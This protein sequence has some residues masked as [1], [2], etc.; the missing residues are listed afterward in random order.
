MWSFLIRIELI[1]DSNLHIKQTPVTTG[2]RNPVGQ[3]YVIKQEAREQETSEAARVGSRAP[4][5]P[6]EQAQEEYY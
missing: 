5:Q 4:H 1:F 6:Q 3:N 2:H